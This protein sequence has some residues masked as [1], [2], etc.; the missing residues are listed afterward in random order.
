MKKFAI[1]F[2]L[3]GAAFYGFKKYQNHV[4]QAPNIEY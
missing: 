1:I 4:N 3:A 2:A